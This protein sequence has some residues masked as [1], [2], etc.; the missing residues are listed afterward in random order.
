M[1]CHTVPQPTALKA[2]EEQL[3]RAPWLFNEYTPRV[4]FDKHVGVPKRER[5]RERCSSQSGRLKT[6]EDG[7]CYGLLGFKADAAREA[8]APPVVEPAIP[9][10]VEAACAQTVELGRRMEEQ[11][12][13]CE[14]RIPCDVGWWKMHIL[15]ADCFICYSGEDVLAVVLK[16]VITALCRYLQYFSKLCRK[17]EQFRKCWGTYC[18]YTQ[19]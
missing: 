6:S 15:Y 2:L 19:L 9:P 10:A 12:V 14:W 13:S 1:T 5:E 8:A 11:E 4:P 16:N 18:T 3:S 17:V 7:L